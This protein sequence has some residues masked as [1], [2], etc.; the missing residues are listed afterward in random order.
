MNYRNYSPVTHFSLTSVKI[1]P[2]EDK[3]QFVLEVKALMKVLIVMGRAYPG[4]VAK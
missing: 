4:W 3:V 2:F 1:W